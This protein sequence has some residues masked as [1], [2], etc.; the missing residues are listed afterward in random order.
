[1]EDN[2]GEELLMEFNVIN[3]VGGF[4]IVFFDKF[5]VKYMNVNFY[6]YDVGVV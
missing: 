3:S 6:G 5:F 4:V 1:M 2:E